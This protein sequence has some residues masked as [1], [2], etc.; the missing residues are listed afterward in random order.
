VG[1]H[2]YSPRAL[3]SQTPVS[4]FG[5]QCRL[6]EHVAAG[7]V[8]SA[9]PKRSPADSVGAGTPP[10]VRCVAGFSFGRRAAKPS[11]A[12]L[13]KGSCVLFHIKCPE[14]GSSILKAADANSEFDKAIA[15]IK[16]LGATPG[17]EPSS[18]EERVEL[19][20]L[21]GHRLALEEIGRQMVEQ[22]HKEQLHKERRAQSPAPPTSVRRE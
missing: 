13:Q 6:A 21:K 20:C 11:A 18:S 2:A 9:A 22:L 4:E 7:C 15:D 17:T 5:R 10:A 19:F 8:A 1:R 3:I 14:C 12:F 16:L